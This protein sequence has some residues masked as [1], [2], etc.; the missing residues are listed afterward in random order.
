MHRA[1]HRWFS[2]ALQRDMELLA[3]GHGGP[4]LL[5]FPTADG[6]FFEYEDQGM[7]AALADRIEGGQ[8]R[9]FTLSTVNR[10]SWLAADVAPA[11]ACCATCSARTAC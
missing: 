8:L 3:F 9:L 2:G 6:A 4:P 5:V 10:E 11:G 1:Y 7:V